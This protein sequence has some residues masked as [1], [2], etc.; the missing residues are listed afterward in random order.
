MCDVELTEFVIAERRIE[1]VALSHLKEVDFIVVRRL[2][3]GLGHLFGASLDTE[4][5]HSGRS[6]HQPRVLA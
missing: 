5:R 4:H 1:D 2:A 6:R 3:H